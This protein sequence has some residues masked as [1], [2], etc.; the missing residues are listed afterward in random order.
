[1]QPDFYRP[2]W[3]PFLSPGWRAGLLLVL[4]WS[5]PRFWLVL[6]AN[7]AGSYQYV[8][9]VFISMWVAPFIL[10]SRRGR[11]DIGMRR[12]RSFG[13]L[14]IGFAAGMASCALLFWLARQ[15][16]GAAEGNW[17]YYIAGTYS[18]L[19]DELDANTRLAFFLIFSGI[20]MTFSPIGEELF[21][22]G[23]IHEHFRHSFGQRAASLLDSL[24]FS[25]VHLA[26]F[27]LIY[28]SGSWKFLFLPGLYWVAALF[29]LCLLF[30]WFRQRSGSI[31]GAILAHAGFN[32]GM[33][34]FIFYH[35]L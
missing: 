12:P 20:S 17:L 10:L 9:L 19:P 8:S 3:R 29:G 26:H 34:Y 25:L 11:R 1:M 21:Y 35:I 15:A 32:V 22:R 2:F 33:N 5:I 7:Q 31:L 13:W 16:Y 14:L 23:L 27:G 4:L 28:T 30:S 24:A 18:N 6:W